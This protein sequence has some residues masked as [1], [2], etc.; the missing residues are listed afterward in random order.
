VVNSLISIG[1]YLKVVYLMYMREPIEGETA[2]SIGIAGGLALALC[3]AGILVLG[4]FPARLWDLARSAA[5]TFP[6]FGP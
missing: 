1:Y 3:G 4:I 5:D 2:P 6:F